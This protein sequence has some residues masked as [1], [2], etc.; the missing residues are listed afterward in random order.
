[1]DCVEEPGSEAID[2]TDR[3]KCYLYRRTPA[4]IK[5]PL[6]NNGISASTSL[7][8]YIANIKNP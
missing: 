6:I 8:F 5:I 3:I 1:M 7:V 2:T 4:L